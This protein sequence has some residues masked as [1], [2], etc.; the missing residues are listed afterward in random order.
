MIGPDWRRFGGASGRP[1]RQAPGRPAPGRPAA[2]G[3]SSALSLFADVRPGSIATSAVSVSALVN[4]AK[5]ILETRIRP[6]WVRGEVTDFKAHRSGHWYFSLRD[7]SATLRCVVWASDQRG[8]GAPPAD[9]TELVA[10]GQMTIYSARADMQLRITALEAVGDGLQRR[11]IERARRALE[12]DGLLA[13]ER[14]RSLPRLPKC[15]AVIT[16]RDGA[17]LHDIVAVARRRAPSLRIVIV[18]ARV[19]GDGAPEAL[20]LAFDRVERWGQADV[21]IVGRG[22]GAKED[23]SAF[24]NEGVAR[25]VAACSVPTISAVGHEVDTTLCDLVADYRAPTPSAAAEAAVPALAHESERARALAALLT[26]A[27][28]RRLTAADT[29]MGRAADGMRRRVIRSTERRRATLTALA[30]QIEA[31]SPLATLARGFAVPRGADGR[32]LTSARDFVL[33]DSFDLL[34]K[35][36]VVG[37]V[38]SRVE[39]AV[40]P[41]PE[42]M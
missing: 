17:A 6:L 16:S 40:E 20:C 11:A 9:G 38:T 14:K 2:A 18:S 33:G 27:M 42:A 1:D 25:A 32:T 26:G 21:V 5:G 7:P 13:I 8:M 30:G 39:P 19:Q 23:L 12:R 10:Y 28:R 22:G 4:A 34:I 36:G 24:N 41:G 31:L 35:D 29:R 15:I 3:E 37:A